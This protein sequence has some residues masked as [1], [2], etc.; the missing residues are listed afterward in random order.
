[1]TA[2][3]RDNPVWI[4]GAGEK[5]QYWLANRDEGGLVSIH[6]VEL[7]GRE[8]DVETEWADI[9][10]RLEPVSVKVSADP[11]SPSPVIGDV[12]RRLP[13]GALQKQIRRGGPLIG[14]SIERH[15]SGIRASGD[16]ADL[17][18]RTTKF[19]GH[20]GVVTSPEEIEEVAAIYRRAW[21]SGEEVT[22]AV[23]E[24][25]HISKSTAGK[26]IMRA[27]KWAQET[28]QAWPERIRR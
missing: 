23:A 20:R 22:K 26:R 16:L 21:G 7:N 1:M 3:S 27:K 9:G 2:P 19:V 6:L 25:F 5:G 8:W 12:L 28:G 11:D 4:E 14:P 13:I 24:H 18:E 10:G 15:P 17:V